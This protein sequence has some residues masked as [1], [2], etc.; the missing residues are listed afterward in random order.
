MILTVCCRQASTIIK[1]IAAYKNNKQKTYMIYA[2]T[3]QGTINELQAPDLRQT[4]KHRL[5]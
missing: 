4:I 3:L 2:I 5:R 1:T